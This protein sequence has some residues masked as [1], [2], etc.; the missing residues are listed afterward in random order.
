MK[1]IIIAI[2]CGLITL[3][4]LS[5]AIYGY[6]WELSAWF[7]LVAVLALAVIV[8]AKIQGRKPF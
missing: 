3:P 8:V 7:G 2:L 4:L 1:T 6:S 5:W